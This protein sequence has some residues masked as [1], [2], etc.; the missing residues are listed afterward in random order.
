[1]SG[2]W[3]NHAHTGTGT[4]ATI[5]GLTAATSYQVH[6]LAVNSDGDGPF[7]SPGAGTTG[8]PTNAAPTAANNTVTTGVGAAY[9]FTAA[10]FGFED[11]DSGD[12]LAS[13]RIVTVPTPG[14]LAL[15]GTAVTADDVVDW[16][17]IEDDKLIFTPVA[18]ASG[19]P[20]TTFTF[21]VN[22]GTD[23]SASAY[24][25]SIDVTSDRPSPSWRTGTRRRARWTIFTTP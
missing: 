16:D 14:E 13:V 3:T 25:M 21:K 7:S 20:Y 19:D 12:E 2:S 15:D 8:T 24:T 10:D 22:D 6:V 17:D 9:T 4:T 23:D 11:A 18:G 5:A 1:M